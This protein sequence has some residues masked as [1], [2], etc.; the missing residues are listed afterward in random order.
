MTRNDT[1]KLNKALVINVQSTYHNLA[2]KRG[3]TV[4]L[5]SQLVL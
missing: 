3:K 4:Y 2:D 1:C 5:I